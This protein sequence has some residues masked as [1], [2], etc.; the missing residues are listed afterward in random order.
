MAGQKKEGVWKVVLNV[1]NGVTDLIFGITVLFM[2]THQSQIQMDVRG[3]FIRMGRVVQGEVQDIGYL[4][5]RLKAVLENILIQKQV[6]KLML[7][8]GG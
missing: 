1:K 5:S 6:K 7:V 8:G 3:M 4:I 2:I